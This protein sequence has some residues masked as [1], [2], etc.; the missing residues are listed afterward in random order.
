MGWTGGEKQPWEVPQKCIDLEEVRS[1]WRQGQRHKMHM[2]KNKEEEEKKSLSLQYYKSCNII[3]IAVMLFLQQPGHLFHRPTRSAD[4]S[5]KRF[6]SKRCY[7]F[8]ALPGASSLLAPYL[9]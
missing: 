8:A 7:H 6:R 3:D 5:M 1:E 2:E 9:L 4:Q